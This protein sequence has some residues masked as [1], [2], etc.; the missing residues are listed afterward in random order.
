MTAGGSFLGYRRPDGRVGVRNHLLVVPTV[1]CSAVVAERIAAA[2]APVGTAL[3]HLAGCG[4][5]GPDMTVTHDT[6]AA[7]CGHP[8]VGA[9]IVVA[10][11]C[12]QV[13]AQR[14]ADE[15]RRHQKPAAVIAIQNEG[16]TVRATNKGIAIA[17]DMVGVLSQAER[18]R[19]DVSSL[20]LSV[21]CGGSDYTSGLA[22]NPAVGRVAD[23][24]VD[25]GGVLYLRVGR[26]AVWFVSGPESGAHGPYRGLAT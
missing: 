2:V 11:G 19:C 12:E 10:L 26:R 16:G 24:L 1:I 21:K 23:T 7:Y 15:A 18:T 13:V 8:N 17:R 6:L 5:L 14:L 3:P 20:V 9:V 4:Q 25:R 22:S